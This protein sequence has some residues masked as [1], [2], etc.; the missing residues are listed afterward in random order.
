[1]RKLAALLSIV[2]ALT[3]GATDTWRWVDAN[4]VTHYSDRP[5]QGAKKVN[6]GS[7]PKPGSVVAPAATAKS[8]SQQDQSARMPYSRCVVVSPARDEV[9]NNVH[10]VS[11]SV[12]IAPALQDADR[13]RIVLNGRPVTSWPGR[14]TAYTLTELDRGTYTLAVQVVDAD[15]MV[16]CNGEA[17]SFHMRQPS[18]LSPLRR[19]KPR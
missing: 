3:A 19:P 11:A 9:F 13:L 1:M 16:M 2:V 15:G 6:I 14:S 8:S 10:S 5:V 12:D 4:G 7:A 17:S 18:L